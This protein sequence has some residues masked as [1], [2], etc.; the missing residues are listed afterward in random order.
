MTRP[1]NV[2]PIV[3]VAQLT[4]NLE[5]ALVEN[6]KTLR[7]FLAHR[8]GEQA[9]LQKVIAADMDLSPTVLSKKFH[10][11]DGDGN[12]FTCDD[13]EAWIASTGDVQSV[14]EYLATKFAPGGDEV[15][16]ARV[17]ARLETLATEQQ[18]LVDTLKGAT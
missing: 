12:R 13:L 3:P 2:A 8:T 15:R 4:L 14:I 18:R 11:N 9:K 5:P 16:R 7:E 1:A 6:W 10:Q 17:L